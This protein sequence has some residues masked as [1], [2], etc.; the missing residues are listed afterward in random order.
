MLGVSEGGLE[1]ISTAQ[2]AHNIY[3]TLPTTTAENKHLLLFL[4]LYV[5]RILVQTNEWVFLP[6]N[7]TDISFFF[8][9]SVLFFFSSFSRVVH[10]VLQ[11]MFFLSQ[12]RK[13]CV[14]PE[15]DV[16]AGAG[17]VRL[18]GRWSGSFS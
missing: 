13:L 1:I 15:H 12:G 18:A 3:R 9:F 2:T 14:C 6:A 4:R 10:S 7:I 11:T 16:T 8:F 17:D 5:L